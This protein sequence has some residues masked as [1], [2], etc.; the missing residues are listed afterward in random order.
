[1]HS[2]YDTY[3]P[4]IYDYT[5]HNVGLLLMALA[6]VYQSDFFE[7]TFLW[8]FPMVSRSCNASPLR[9]FIQ[10]A[11]PCHIQPAR[12]KKILH[13]QLHIKIGHRHGEQC[14]KESFIAFF[15]LKCPHFPVRQ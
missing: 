12:S 1:M 3:Q 10:M 8:G 5:L 9:D 15:S 7:M 4:T 13:S 2:G 11:T 14:K 6:S